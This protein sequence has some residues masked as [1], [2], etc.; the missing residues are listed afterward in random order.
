MEDGRSINRDLTPMNDPNESDPN[1]SKQ[2]E[3]L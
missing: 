3:W 2:L 1:E